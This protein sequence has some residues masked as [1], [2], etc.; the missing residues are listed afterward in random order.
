[1]NRKLMAQAMDEINDAYIAEAAPEPSERK[2]IMA[3]KRII[4]LA[5][6]AALIL[7]LGATAYAVANYIRTVTEETRDDYPC[8]VYRFEG[9]EPETA[10]DFRLT[11]WPESVLPIG[12]R[13]TPADL[14]GDGVINGTCSLFEVPEG[15]Y[16][17]DFVPFDMDGDGTVYDDLM[18]EKEF[19]AL[20][21]KDEVYARRYYEFPSDTK[22]KI[23][24]REG[25][26]PSQAYGLAADEGWYQLAYLYVRD[27][28]REKIGT[29]SYVV[30]LIQIEPG[31]DY[32]FGQ[33][34]EL[35][36]E[37][38]W[39]D[40]L[41]ADYFLTTDAKLILRVFNEAE[42]WIIQI[43][44]D[45]TDPAQFAYMERIVRAMEVRQS[46][47]PYQAADQSFFG[48]VGIGVPKG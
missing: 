44:T 18:I 45:G 35:Q 1:M 24:V 7:S 5:L 21:L 31:V 27:E 15:Y 12:N 37:E 42:G 26:Y 14:D 11:E 39:S 29:G 8:V 40:D 47:R 9:A 23:R 33:D 46:D 20:M 16:E 32:L 19:I 4:T 41:L 13:Y 28:A 48:G 43:D 30:Q 10:M 25:Y 34:E 38:R 2:A 22:G 17:Q 3:K 6:A 36:K